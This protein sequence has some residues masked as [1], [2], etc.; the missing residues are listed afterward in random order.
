MRRVDYALVVSLTLLATA[1]RADS[2]DPL[3]H[4]DVVSEIGLARLADEAG[5]AKLDSWLKSSTR[6]DLQLV[7]TRATPYAFAPERLI[8]QL[9]PLLCGRDPSLAPEVGLA[10]ASIAQ[11]L[12]PSE[13]AAREASM[14][15]VR[16]A[17]EA[18]RCVKEQEPAPRSDLVTAA[19]LLDAAL[20]QI[21][22]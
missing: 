9:A 4:A 3:A 17:R 22:R 2:T 8:P 16:A 20:T 7:A 12:K 21:E 10:L 1:T 19:L 15:D 14:A 6:R 18:L 5:D 13:F 11:S